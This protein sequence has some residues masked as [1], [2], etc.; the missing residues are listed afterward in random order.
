MAQDISS[1]AL[2]VQTFSLLTAY[3]RASQ[4]GNRSMLTCGFFVRSPWKMSET[5][6]S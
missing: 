3:K 6:G 4:V 2:I 1:A 5:I